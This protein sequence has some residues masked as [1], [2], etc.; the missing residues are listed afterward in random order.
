[1]ESVFEACLDNFMFSFIEKAENFLKANY[2]IIIDV[3][4]E[5]QTTGV[6]MIA[7]IVFDGRRTQKNVVAQETDQEVLGLLRR[8]VME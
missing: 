7:G 5:F 2:V 4:K 8:S 3:F 6:F 1:M